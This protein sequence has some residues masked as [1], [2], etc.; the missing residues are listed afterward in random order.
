MGRWASVRGSIPQPVVVVAAISAGLS[1]RPG[2]R[3]RTI[4]MALLAMRMLGE[5]VHGYIYEDDDDDD[6]TFD[7]DDDDDD[8]VSR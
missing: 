7:Q 4:V 1:A 6:D 3:L 5:F 8:D 2:R